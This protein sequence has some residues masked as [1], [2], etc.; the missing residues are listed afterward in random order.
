[1]KR[2][3]LIFFFFISSCVIAQTVS[4]ERVKLEFDSFA[5]EH[6]IQLSDELIKDSTL[7]ASLKLD[8]YLMRAVSFYS[9]GDEI[10]TRAS[11]TEILKINKDYL[12][13]PAE[14]SPILIPLFNEVK[15]EYLKTLIVPEQIDSTRAIEVP[16]VFDSA[17]MKGSVVRNIVLPG[18]GQLHSGSTI[19][20][21]IISAISVSAASSMIYYISDTNQKEKE[22]LKETNKNLIQEKYDAFNNSYKIRN[23]LIISYAAIW[24]FSQLDLFFSDDT[25]FM[26]EAPLSINKTTSSMNDINFGVRIPF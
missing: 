24:I 8:V 26:K 10:N 1:M 23:A 2:S 22:Y 12:P 21:I 19:K 17:L 16:K 18:W 7:S 3:F 4:Y 11:F 9:L 5:Y 14:V 25:I 20:G 15:S 13:N 6:V